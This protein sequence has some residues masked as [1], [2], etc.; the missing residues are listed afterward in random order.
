MKF[1]PNPINSTVVVFSIRR[2]NGVRISGHGYGP[3]A[4]FSWPLE[5]SANANDNMEQQQ[6]PFPYLQAFA[7]IWAAVTIHVL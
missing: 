5:C 2:I 3:E 4:L 6:L 7:S 1:N